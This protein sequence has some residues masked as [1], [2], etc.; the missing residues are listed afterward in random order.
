LAIFITPIFNPIHKSS[1]VHVFSVPI[2]P[3]PLLLYAFARR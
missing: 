1:T 2:I 3:V